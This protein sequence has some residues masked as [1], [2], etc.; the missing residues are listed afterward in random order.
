[1]S[2]QRFRSTQIKSTTNNALNPIDNFPRYIS[3]AHNI[4]SGRGGDANGK[5]KRSMHEIV[6]LLY[7]FC[8]PYII[9]FR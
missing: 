8:L 5:P 2:L 6:I 7:H 1:M 4:L 3:T 9:Q